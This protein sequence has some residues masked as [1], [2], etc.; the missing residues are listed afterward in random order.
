MI[1]PRR[2]DIRIQSFAPTAWRVGLGVMAPC[3]WTD[4]FGDCIDDP[5]R[6]TLTV[7]QQILGAQLPDQSGSAQPARVSQSGSSFSALLNRYATPIMIG[8]AALLGLALLK[9]GRR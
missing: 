7:F 3:N 8:S 5:N 6:T 1:T 9:G 4:E 2:T